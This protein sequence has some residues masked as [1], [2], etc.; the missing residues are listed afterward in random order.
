MILRVKKVS[1]RTYN[2]KKHILPREKPRQ[3]PTAKMNLAGCK[4]ARVS[5][6]S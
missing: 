4:Y 2:I 5:F 6:H 1:K 3:L